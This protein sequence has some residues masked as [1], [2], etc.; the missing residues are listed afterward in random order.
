MT[1]FWVVAPRGLTDVYRC[2]DPPFC[3]AMMDEAARTYETSATTQKTN[4]FHF[5]NRR[6]ISVAYFSFTPVSAAKLQIRIFNRRDKA[7]IRAPLDFP[8]AIPAEVS[9]AVLLEMEDGARKSETTAGLSGPLCSAREKESGG[10]GFIDYLSPGWEITLLPTRTSD[11]PLLVVLPTPSHCPELTPS[12]ES[13]QFA[14]KLS[15]PPDRFLQTAIA[16]ADPD[17]DP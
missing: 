17:S 14:Q 8:T 1:V 12:S 9:D 5:S 4:E 6:V 2:R 7:N 15:A 16:S 10:V 13:C 3:L 11:V